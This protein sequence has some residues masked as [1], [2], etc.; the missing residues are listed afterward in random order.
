MGNEPSVEEKIEANRDK[1]ADDITD[2]KA[3]IKTLKREEAK[4]TADLLKIPRNKGLE[5]RAKAQ[6]IASNQIMQ[7]TTEK[8]ILTLQATDQHFGNMRIHNRLVESVQ[9]TNEMHQDIIE[10]T[11]TKN[12]Q[13]TVTQF[14]RNV[15]T[16][17]KNQDNISSTLM[18]GLDGLEQNTD[19]IVQ[20]IL[21]MHNIKIEL[22]SP[23]MPQHG[24]QQQLQVNSQVQQ[25]SAPQVISLIDLPTVGPTHQQRLDALTRKS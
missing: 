18:D 21:D 10:N 17:A 12:V 22:E 23:Q 24:Q 8:H 13:K 9:S 2:L 16:M 3:E 7:V 25:E 6:L 1:V 5:I 14:Q 15:N 4:L 20:K 19:D 11:N